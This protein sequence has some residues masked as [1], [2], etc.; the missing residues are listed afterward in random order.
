MLLLKNGYTYV[1]YSSLEAIIEENKEGYYL[2]LRRTQAT[3]KKSNP[4]LQPWLIY[5]L[6][7]LQ[8]QKQRL[9]VKLEHDKAMHLSL[10]QLSALIL[11]F[12]E[13]HT[14]ASIADIVDATNASR[15]TIKKHVT[16]L[17]EQGYLKRHGQ[18]RGTWYTRI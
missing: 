10:P 18:G 11:Q 6:R 14:R 13:Q 15:N 12:I 3:L 2:A 4:D 1:P 16:T 9:E 7:I 5:F 8:K 17:V